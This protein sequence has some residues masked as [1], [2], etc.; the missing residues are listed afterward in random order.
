MRA[1]EA[2]MKPFDQSRYYVF[3]V[4]LV[5]MVPEG[6]PPGAHSQRRTNL[7]CCCRYRDE[8]VIDWFTAFECQKVLGVAVP[9]YSDDTRSVCVSLW[10]YLPHD[11]GSY[12]VAH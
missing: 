1:I 7:S 12:N 8:G 6:S 4:S 3:F 9:I 10:R 11:N 2:N 5:R